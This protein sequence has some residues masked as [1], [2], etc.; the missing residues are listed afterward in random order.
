VRLAAAEDPRGFLDAYP[1]PVILDEVQCAPDLL[2]YVKERIDAARSKRGQYLLTG[3][4]NLLLM[5]RVTES[6]AGRAA[7]LRLLP[8]SR[9]EIEGRPRAALPWESNAKAA[10]GRKATFRELWKGLLRGGYPEPALQPSLDVA[11]W[12]ASYVQTYLERDVRTL[13]AV[14]DLVD[15]QRFLVALAAR[16][17]QLVNFEELGRDLGVTGK[18]I[19]AW[20]SVLE[21]GGQVARVL[22]YFANVGKR[23]VKRPKIYLLDT[24]TLCHLLQL[25]E[26]DQLRQGIAAGPVFE[27]AVFGQLHRLLAHRG[28]PPRIHF[29]RTA[30]GHEVDFVIEDGQ[31]LMP[32]EAK[33]TSTPLPRDARMIEAFQRLFGDR[34]GPG[35]LVCLCRERFR[36][37]STVEAV[38]L[39]SF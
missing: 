34:A 17:G 13:R 9:R 16:A 32:V 36:L 31:R 27:T 35:L 14:G 25:R 5:E 15:F 4:Q 7:M 20:L 28:E 19:K 21:A 26:T 2:P 12:H 33:L 38:P 10:R 39:G 11:L 24:G 23:L 29:W 3:S 37:T 18:T 6:L 22:P 8:L 30:A 1:P